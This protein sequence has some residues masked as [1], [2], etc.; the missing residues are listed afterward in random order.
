MASRAIDA[1]AT[2]LL[3]TWIAII[4]VAKVT[5][6][7]ANGALDTEVARVAAEIIGVVAADVIVVASMALEGPFVATATD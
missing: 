4:A 6:A 7:E 2:V 1:T 5:V 3:V